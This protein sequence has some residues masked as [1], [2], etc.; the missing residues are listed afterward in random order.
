M[1]N[2]R[3]VSIDGQKIEVE[4][5]ILAAD[6]YAEEFAG[7]LKAPYSGVMEDDMLS[8]HNRSKTTITVRVKA[9]KSGKPMR[10]RNGEYVLTDRDGV[11]V[12]VPNPAYRG[13]DVIALLRYVWAMGVAA[14]SIQES[15]EDFGKRM[16]HV[17]FVV[18]E[19]ASVFTTVIYD[20][21]GGCIFRNPEG[22]GDAQQPD[23]GQQADELPA[24]EGREGVAGE[25]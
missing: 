7:N 1:R 3:T 2:R 9:T 12:E 15:W 24:D 17:D 20:L 5:S 11:E 18:R 21:G 14:G 4:A 19:V 13:V 6:V 8:T 10:D 22:L 25:G 16:E 23:E